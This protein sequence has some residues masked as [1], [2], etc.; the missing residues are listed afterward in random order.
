MRRICLG[1]F[2]ATFA[3]LVWLA[4]SASAGEN[5]VRY[6]D[7]GA[8]EHAPVVEVG[9]FYRDYDGDGYYEYRRPA[10][11][12]YAPPPRTRV[13]VV[14]EPEVYSPPPRRYYYYQ[15]AP[16]SGFYYRGRGVSIGIGF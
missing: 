2:F 11:R 10:P 8:R 7:Y 1:A 13:V 5:H 16:A 9:H 14:P 12:Y 15:P 6:A 4:S 3:S